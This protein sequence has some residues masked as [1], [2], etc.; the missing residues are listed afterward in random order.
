MDS[1]EATLA[2]KRFKELLNPPPEADDEGLIQHELFSV[3]DLM[4]DKLNETDS[5]CITRT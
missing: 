3:E 4:G 5:D 1:N 2:V